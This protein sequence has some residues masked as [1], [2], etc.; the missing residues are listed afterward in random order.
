MPSALPEALFVDADVL[1]GRRSAKL[2]SSLD[3]PIHNRL[4]GIP[5]EAE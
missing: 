5:G 2:E 3:G 4:D 1:D